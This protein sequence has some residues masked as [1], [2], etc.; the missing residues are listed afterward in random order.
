MRDS[1]GGD[2]WPEA[3]KLR[4]SRSS[5]LWAEA[6]KLRHSRS[7]DLWVGVWGLRQ[8]VVGRS[9]R[10]GACGAQGGGRDVAPK[11]LPTDHPPEDHST[12]HHHPNEQPERR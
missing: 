1:W 10:S 12:E 4:H 3:G 7:S 5:D 2:L 6:G 8:G 11:P 9:D